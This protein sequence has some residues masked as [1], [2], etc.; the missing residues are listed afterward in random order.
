M[1]NGTY[2]PNANP[3]ACDIP[4]PLRPR[5][6]FFH[7]NARGTGCAGIDRESVASG[8]RGARGGGR[9]VKYAG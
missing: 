6:S 8:Q 1:D 9:I 7:A 5:L 4:P 3:S 2:E